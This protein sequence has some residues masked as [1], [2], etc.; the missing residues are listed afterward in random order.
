LKLV[1]M[2]GRKDVGNAKWEL[3]DLS[4]DLSEETNL[5]RSNPE[6]LAELIT[7]WEQ[8]NGEMREPMF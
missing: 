1:R 2:G 8:M 3:Y 7:L 6:K 4:K 5:A